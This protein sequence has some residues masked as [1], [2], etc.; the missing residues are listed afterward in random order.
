MNFSS[1]IG[2]HY[3]VLDC[4][5]GESVSKNYITF[6]FKGG[7]A[8]EVRKNRRVRA[9]GKIFQSL[10]FLVDIKEDR[11]DARI[12][13]YPQDVIQEKLDQC[14]RLLQFTRQMDML[15]RC[16][17]SVDRLAEMFLSGDYHLDPEELCKLEQPSQ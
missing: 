12:Y 7:A 2:Y 13:K 11:V 15:M 14:G 16:E 4:Y 8:D 6:A 1:R 9:I 17:S 5:C 10:D 3:S